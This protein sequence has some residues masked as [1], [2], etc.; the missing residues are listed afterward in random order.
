MAVVEHL[1]SRIMDALSGSSVNT[2]IIDNTDW[3]EIRAGIDGVNRI[4]LQEERFRRILGS[5]MPSGD[6]SDRL[7]IYNMNQALPHLEAAISAVRRVKL[8]DYIRVQPPYQS[9][10]NRA[11]LVST[12]GH[13]VH[14][15]EVGAAETTHTEVTITKHSL[16]AIR[17]QVKAGGQPFII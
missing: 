15:R 12:W 8:D 3:N 7:S 5:S 4:V 14:F 10:D 9:I 1:G 6:A 13:S 2:T 17:I 16:E 11:H